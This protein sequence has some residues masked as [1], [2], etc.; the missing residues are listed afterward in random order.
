M[1]EPCNRREWLKRFAGAAA[2]TLAPGLS[3]SVQS[4]AA[5]A[6]NSSAGIKR[7]VLFIAVDDLKPLLGCYGDN[8]IKTPNID[9]LAAQGLRF[10]FAY[11]QQ[12]ICA[13]S[14][15]GILT[16]MRP[17][18]LGIYDLG[19]NLRDKHPDVVTLPQ[20]FKQHGW[21]AESIG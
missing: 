19:T 9:K 21:H 8:L 10:N 18:T 2:L 5:A 15:F 7:N 6:A 14:R 1:M 13:P 17:A 4:L 12:A 16:G 11:C 3:H 20:L